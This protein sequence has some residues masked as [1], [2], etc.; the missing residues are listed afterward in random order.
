LGLFQTNNQIF[1]NRRYLME[2]VE[3]KRK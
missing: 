2:I 3:N 1:G